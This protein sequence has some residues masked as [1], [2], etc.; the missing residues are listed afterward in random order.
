MRFFLAF[1]LLVPSGLRAQ[2]ERHVLSPDGQFKFRV[3]VGQPKDALWD[4][5]GYQVLFR[6]KPLVATSWLGIDIRDQEPYLGEKTGLVSSESSSN[7]SRY[8]SLVAHYLQNGSVGRRIDLEIRA[9][10]DGVAFRYIV[11]RSN[12]LERILIRNEVTEFNLAQPAALSQLSAK[13][14]FDL[15]VIL[16]QHG[17]GWIAVTDAGP[18]TVSGEYPRTYLIRSSDGLVTNLAQSSKVPKVA[19]VGTTPLVWPWRVLLVG[20][21]GERLLQSETLN[22]LKR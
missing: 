3:F 14:D 19:F 20:T 4:R 21:D 17:I 1:F 11:P 22:S 2:D 9:Y 10:N 5:I 7:G 12:E 15:P 16:E 8:N 13:P 6:G 18:G